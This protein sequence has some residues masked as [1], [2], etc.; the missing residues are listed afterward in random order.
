MDARVEA[1]F[2]A[3]EGSAP[4]ERVESV[5]AIEGGLLGD[6]Y[7]NGTGHYAPYD[8]CEVTMVDADAIDRIREEAGIDLTDG[9]HRRNL[10]VR[11]ADLEALL[12]ATVRVG[13][14]AVRPTRRRPP[15]AHVEQL[16][17][18]DGVASALTNRG[19]VCADVVEPGR[20][21]TGDELELLEAD[22][23]TEGRR[24]AERLAGEAADGSRES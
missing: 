7:C 16:A 15:C 17:G 10:V 4:M 19:G 2:V 13:D 18:E 14:A 8:V 6:R 5:E 9:R 20:I 21:R 22:P 24:I 23:R 11:G 1:I 12:E 3:P